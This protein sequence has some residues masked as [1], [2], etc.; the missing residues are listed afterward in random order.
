MKL[1]GLIYVHRISDVLMGGI[2]SRN[3]RMFR[4]LCG[5]DTL[6]NVVIVTKKLVRP[7]ERCAKQSS[8]TGSSNQPLT[9]ER[10]CYGMI[11]QWNP[12]TTFFISYR[13]ILFLSKFNVSSLMKRRILDKRRQHKK[14][15]AKFKI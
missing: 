13:T 6:K 15:R 3:F 1:S 2:S 9:R 5:D 4:K 8:S 12:S 7:R 14:S 11:T 10:R